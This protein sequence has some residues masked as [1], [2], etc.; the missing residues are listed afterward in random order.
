MTPA[1]DQ[2]IIITTSH[3][4]HIQIPLVPGEYLWKLTEQ[5]FY[6]PGVIPATQPPVS[7]HW[8]E[9]KALHEAKH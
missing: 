8:Q 5:W 2:V 1:S 9:H 4:Y 6:K 7:N 3:T